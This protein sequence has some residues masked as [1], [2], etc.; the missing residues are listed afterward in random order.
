MGLRF[1]FTLIIAV[2]AYGATTTTRVA[3]GSCL[4]VFPLLTMPLGDL[5]IPRAT[6]E[7]LKKA[8]WKIVSDILFIPIEVVQARSGLSM[9]A[10]WGL[11]EALKEKNLFF[12]QPRRFVSIAVLKSLPP[13]TLLELPV[14]ELNLPVR[15]QNVCSQNGI[16]TIALL[17]Q[18]SPDD[19]IRLKNFGVGSLVEVMEILE[20]LNLE[21]TGRPSADL[22]EKVKVYKALV[23]QRAKPLSELGLD[24]REC[25]SLHMK[26]YFSVDELLR[27][28]PRDVIGIL[29]LDRFGEIL[30][31][32]EKDGYQPNYWKHRWPQIRARLKFEELKNQSLT[33]RLSQPVGVMP[34]RRSAAQVVL[35][36]GARTIGDLVDFTER[37]LTDKDITIPTIREIRATLALIGLQFARE[38]AVQAEPFDITKD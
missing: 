29:G 38:R 28:D 21:L 14:S 9:D 27:G 4:H 1:V 17:C 8:R 22:K 30:Q 33:V 26:G 37:D 24:S 5:N 18:K 23:A 34:L 19:L 12:N 2:S 11:I 15:A 16:H 13:E 35:S 3:A 7:A 32:A 20:A 25:I 36:L 6:A 31:R 10:M